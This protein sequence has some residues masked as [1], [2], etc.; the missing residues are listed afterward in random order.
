VG[1]VPLQSK[2]NMGKYRPVNDENL[3]GYELCID[4][5]GARYFKRSYRKFYLL[6]DCLPFRSI[7]MA[8]VHSG[9]T[10]HFIHS[11]S[12]TYQIQHNL[13]QQQ[14]TVIGR[15]DRFKE[16]IMEKNEISYGKRG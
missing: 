15:S 10:N 3:H 7:I 13:L 1:V 9:I 2:W 4:Q 12:Y 6:G 11:W 5:Y 14:G 8:L 16:D